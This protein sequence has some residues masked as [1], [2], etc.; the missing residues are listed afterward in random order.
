MNITRSAESQHTHDQIIQAMIDVH[1]GKLSVCINP[2]TEHNYTACEKLY[3]DCI[4]KDCEEIK[5]IIEVETKETIVASK[6]PSWEESARC[7]ASIGAIFYLVVPI[8]DIRETMKLCE[9]NGCQYKFGV[10]E[11]IDGK[12]DLTFQK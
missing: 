8:D 11:I 9:S 4:L 2:G 12:I 10:Y 3:P 7:A 1:E 5:Y 6:I